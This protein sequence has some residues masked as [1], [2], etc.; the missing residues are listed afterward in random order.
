MKAPR[1]DGVVMVGKALVC[2][3]ALVQGDEQQLDFPLAQRQYAGA[4][5]PS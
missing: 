1:V 4:H 5:R 3:F 2:C